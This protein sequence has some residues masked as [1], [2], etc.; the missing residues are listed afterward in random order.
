MMQ[1]WFVSMLCR[2]QA[3]QD[4]WYES[5]TK[6]KGLSLGGKGLHLMQ[7][8]MHGHL[9]TPGM[10]VGR[11]GATRSTQDGAR[12]ETKIPWNKQNGQP[13]EHTPQ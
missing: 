1:A 10:L 4:V 12:R 8:C 11:H 7:P 5:R 3:M 6:A 9:H 2:E 13:Q